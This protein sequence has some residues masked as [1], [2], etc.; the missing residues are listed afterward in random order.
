[1]PRK[2][3]IKLRQQ[4][5]LAEQ[6]LKMAGYER[7]TGPAGWKPKVNIEAGARLRL[8]WAAENDAARYQLLRSL[9]CRDSGMKPSEFDRRVDNNTIHK[10]PE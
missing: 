1:M 7:C 9:F 3:N 2:S 6:A 4:L 8:R 5:A 10:L